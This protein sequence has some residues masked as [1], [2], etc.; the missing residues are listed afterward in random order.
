MLPDEQTQSWLV[1][2]K[3]KPTEQIYPFQWMEN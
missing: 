3:I 2:R 1:N